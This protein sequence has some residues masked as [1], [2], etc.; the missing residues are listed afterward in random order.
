MARAARKATWRQTR[1]KI[2]VAIW[3]SSSSVALF[4]P[5]FAPYA[6]DEGLTRAGG[7]VS[8]FEPPSDEALLGTDNLGRDV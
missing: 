8:R 7:F 5:F 4:G 1:T 2:G 3:S 6:P